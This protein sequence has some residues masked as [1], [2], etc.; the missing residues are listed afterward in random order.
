M[1]RQARETGQG[2]SALATARLVKVFGYTAADFG[3]SLAVSARQGWDRHEVAGHGTRW[4]RHLLQTAGIEVDQIG[5]APTAQG[6][7]LVSNHQSYA[8]IPVIMSRVRCTFLA[9]REVGGWP[10]IG[11]AT[12]YS[13]AIMVARDE[14]QSR[15]EARAGLREALVKDRI[16]AVVFPEGTTTSGP[17]MLDFRPGVFWLAAAAQ[18][19]VIPIAIRYHDPADAWTGDDTFVGHFLR[20]FRWPAMHV[21]ISFGSPITHEDGE[22]LREQA[23]AV[24]RRELARMEGLD[25]NTSREMR[26]EERPCQRDKD[27]TSMP[28][29]TAR[30]AA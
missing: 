20:R 19:P 4:S 29:T 17:G 15:R 7:L 9:K 2:S 18:L 6:A 12:R 3:Y 1:A 14:A 27:R 10:L 8:D 11:Q 28:S 25:F 24:V 26:I 30:G 21:S 13:G 5:Q 16:S 23:Q 22:A